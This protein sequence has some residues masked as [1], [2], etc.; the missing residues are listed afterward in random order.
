MVSCRKRRHWKRE[1][2]R[3]VDDISFYINRKE[4][5]GLVGESGCG[6]TTC[7]KMLLRII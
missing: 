5:L 4:V 6:K 3:A 7:G 1:I 2:L